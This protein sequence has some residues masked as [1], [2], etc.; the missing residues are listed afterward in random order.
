MLVHIAKANGVLFSAE[1]DSLTAPVSE[2]EVTVLPH[3]TP[4]AGI[5]RPGRLIVKKGG[6]VVFEHDVER[7]VVEVTPESATVLL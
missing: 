5:L 7:G 4:L 1:A 3:H 6:V 2:G